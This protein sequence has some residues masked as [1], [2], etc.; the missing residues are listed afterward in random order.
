MIL[1]R[2]IEFVSIVYFDP[3]ILLGLLVIENH[4]FVIE[5]SIF[6]TSLHFVLIE[7][8]IC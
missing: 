3:G 2:K 8:S 4:L 5:K 7:K 1:Y 6:Y